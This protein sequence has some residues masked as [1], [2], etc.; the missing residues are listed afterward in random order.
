MKKFGK[1]LIPY[2]QVKGNSFRE[3]GDINERVKQLNVKYE[4]QP[5]RIKCK[6]CDF[7]LEGMDFERVG[8]GYVA[9]NR[10]GHVNGLHDDSSEFSEFAYAG[11][12][13]EYSQF[14]A[15]Y[16]EKEYNNR[17]SSIYSPKVDF[18]LDILKSCGEDVNELNFL[19]Y[20]AGSGYMVSALLKS[21]LKHVAGVEVSKG[22]VKQANE[23]LGRNIID[24]LELSESVGYIQQS[25]ANIICMIGVLEHLQNPR[26]ILKAI[27]ENNNIKYFY[28]DF[29]LFSF[30]VYLETIFPDYFH[31]HLS[32]DHT[33]VYTPE[34][35]EYLCKEF[36]FEIKGEWFFGADA[37]DMMRF[38]SL[39]LQD[40]G[41]SDRFT[42]RF[43]GDYGKMIDDIQMAF[44]KNSLSSEVH[45]VLK[46]V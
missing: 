43:M 30:S 31:R 14:Y 8:I 11:E 34:S 17:V 28:V 42:E 29:P 7:E 19:D 23:V 37:F 2:M 35:I 21:G 25:S 6:N 16:S 22:Q 1:S 36:G 4:E 38:F 9:C 45:S 41:S 40:L 39:K 18:L 12:G 26:E 27:S 33:H 32:A 3:D 15:S 44:D 46:K 5:E 13:D 24:T 20:G 10:C